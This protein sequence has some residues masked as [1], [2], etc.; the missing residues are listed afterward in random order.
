MQSNWLMI[1]LGLIVLGLIGYLVLLKRQIRQLT[2]AVVSLP[3]TAE[4]GSRL[5]LDFR[6]E[7]LIQ[8]I[9]ALN[10][11]VNTFEQERHQVHKAERQLQLSITGLSHDLRTPLTA[12]KGY[13]QLLQQ[14]QDPFK[15]ARYLK[16]IQESITKLTNMTDSFYELTRLDAQQKQVVLK[17]IILNECVEEAFLEFFESL[18]RHKIQ[19]HF[20]PLKCPITVQA[21]VQ[22][23]TRVLQNVI[24]NILRYAKG[25]VQI[26]YECQEDWGIVRIGN[27][28]LVD[29]HLVIQQV[30][31]QFYTA[32]GS[33][34][35][36]E[37][38]G[39]G[40][41]LSRQL[42]EAMGAVMTAELKENQFVIQLKLKRV[43]KRTQDS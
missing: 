15:R 7:N 38:S 3:T 18:N 5:F 1:I 41:Y 10:Q 33:R 20:E 43:K 17:P 30:F 13:V 36:T 22:L 39:L 14:T 35:N 37:S 29:H 28:M 9:T 34:T 42:A 24:Q 25:Q 8:L 32:S 2:K 16:M 31:E 11:M 23:L 6:E 12:I 26:T 27:P 4:N 40:L 21:D 19:V